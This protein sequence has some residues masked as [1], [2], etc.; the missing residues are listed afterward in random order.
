[1]IACVS[2]SSINLEESLNCLRYANRARNIQN[3]AVINLDAG[4]RLEY[5]IIDTGNIK[6]KQYDK[7][8]DLGYY[9]RNKDVLDLDYMYYIKL[10]TNPMDQVFNV[11]FK[12]KK[13]LSN[14][15]KS[16]ILFIIKHTV[17]ICSL[18]LNL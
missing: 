15:F 16:V 11:A 3:N 5:V 10:L 7:L 2:P 17:C 14:I 13:F 8:E 18:N 4:S 12:E 6:D 1:M 9:K